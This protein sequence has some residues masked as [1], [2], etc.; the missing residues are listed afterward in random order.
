[1]ELQ[2]MKKYKAIIEGHDQTQIQN[3]FINELEKRSHKNTCL[4]I[5]MMNAK[6]KS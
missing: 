3:N 1:M 6:R 4:M 5:C 2:K